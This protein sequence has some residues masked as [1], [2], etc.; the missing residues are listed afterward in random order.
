MHAA[1][2]IADRGYKFKLQ[3][4]DELVFIVDDKDV[5][6]AEKIIH[7]EMVRRPS[8]APDLPLT[9]SIG[10]GQSYGDAK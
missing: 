4:H 9:A 6:N 2:R 10:H 7:E 3:S 5:D 8:W 1:L